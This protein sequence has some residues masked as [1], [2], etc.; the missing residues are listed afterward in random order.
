MKK[1][2]KQHASAENLQS[3]KRRRKTIKAKN[4]QVSENKSRDV[5]EE[6]SVGDAAIIPT[7]EGDDSNKIHEEEKTVTL[8]ELISD[9][10]DVSFDQIDL[11][12]FTPDTQNL[13]REVLG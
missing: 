5:M 9:T 6:E 7:Q 12:D 3:V 11:N 10:T 13:I 4:D 1:H 8:K 2:L